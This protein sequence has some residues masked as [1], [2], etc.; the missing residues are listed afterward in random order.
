MPTGDRAAELRKYRPGDRIADWTV[1]KYLRGTNLIRVRCICGTLAEIQRANL[2]SGASTRCSACYHSSCERTPESRMWKQILGSAAKRNLSVQVTKE[3]VF[4]LLTDQNHRC[5]LSG[6]PI[7]IASTS[8]EHYRRGTTASLDRIDSFRGYED[9]N[10]QWIHKDLNRMKSS[11]SDEYFI[12]M[13]RHV[14]EYQSRT[15][16][17]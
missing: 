14:A 11:H 10:L 17:N 2:F 13:C 8:A 16:V 6:L 4:K 9:G 12:K 7:T 3:Y 15:H 5:A 1:V